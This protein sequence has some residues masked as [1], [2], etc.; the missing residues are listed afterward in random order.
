MIVAV[1]IISHHLSNNSDCFSSLSTVLSIIRLII[2]SPQRD[3]WS[4]STTET[5]EADDDEVSS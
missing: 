5:T 4:N 2:L 1:S 3:P